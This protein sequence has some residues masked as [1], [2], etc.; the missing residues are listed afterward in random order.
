VTNLPPDIKKEVEEDPL[1]FVME[2]GS[3]GTFGNMEFYDTY[4]VH[5][6]AA[7]KYGAE[8]CLKLNID[9]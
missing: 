6:K 2:G 1:Y 3:D 8:I 9:W 4:G 5:A 7:A